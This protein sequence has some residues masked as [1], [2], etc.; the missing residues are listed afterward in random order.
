MG[1]TEGGRLNNRIHKQVYY[2]GAPA[3]IQTCNPPRTGTTEITP[4]ESSKYTANSFTETVD[5]Q[6]RPRTTYQGGV[7][8]EKIQALLTSKVNYQSES[9]RI[10][11]EAAAC[12]GY[13]PLF[14]SIIPPVTV[15]PPLPAPP[16]PPL[17]PGT[18]PLLCFNKKY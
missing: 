12:P 17:I 2:T 16:L 4:A 1:N 5:G 3:V 13:T 9:I 7:S 8:Q 15:C 11:A 6:E 18:N 10:A 14:S